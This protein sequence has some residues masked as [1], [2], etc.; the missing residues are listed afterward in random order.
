MMMNLSPVTTC[1]KA[2]KLHMV[3]LLRLVFPSQKLNADK[4]QKKIQKYVNLDLKFLCGWLKV[5]KI[6]LNA[7]KTELITFR[8]PRKKID[9]DL[10]IKISGKK[11]TPSK[12]VKYLGF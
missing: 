4:S 11:I 9:Y 6:S 12:Y 3:H 10:K 8:D 1:V 5:N 7:S 2:T